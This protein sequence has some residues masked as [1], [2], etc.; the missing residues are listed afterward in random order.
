MTDLSRYR[1]NV[2]E[3]VQP[4]GAWQLPQGGINE[5]ETPEEA[6][7]RELWEETGLQK[8]E[9]SV[10]LVG[11]VPGD[12]LTYDFP[13]NAGGFFKKQGF[14]GQAQYFFLFFSEDDGLPSKTDLTGKGGEPPEFTRMEWRPFPEVVD[15][16][17]EFKRPVYAELQ[18]RS[19]PM[20]ESFLK[21]RNADMKS[22]G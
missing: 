6:A 15:G 22:K 16:I 4:A 20:I 11:Q 14:I 13:E 17:V 5:G 10:E 21:S 9:C 18:S 7:W 12:P 2:G 3:R 1:P 8:G 19:V